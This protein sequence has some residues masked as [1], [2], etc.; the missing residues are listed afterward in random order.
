MGESRLGLVSA[1]ALVV[2]CAAWTDTVVVQGSTTFNNRLM[3]RYQ[4][5]IEASAG[6]TLTVLPSK[7]SLGL[8]A[9]FEK[10]GDI[11]MISAPLEAEV[12][13]LRKTH[14]DLPFDRLRVF[15]MSRT[16]M[17]FAVNPNNPVRSASLDEVRRV[18]LGEITNWRVL[19]GPDLP[20]R[21]VMVREGG[22]VQASIENEL[23]HG[24]H[25]NAP[26]PITV[27]ISS[28]VVKVVAQ[29]PS[30]LGLAQLPTLLRSGLPELMTDK[31]IEQRLSMVTLGEPNA[32]VKKV[33]DA[34][35]QISESASID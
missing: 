29:E 24:A 12:A 26:D 5:A 1:S 34:T 15:E 28:Q 33:I 27:Q 32:A 18:L 4:A 6:A 16:R 25:I 14:P 19:G 3:V 35:R 23:L 22:G 8:L 20:I 31:P 17:A 21:I 11:A 9:L 30:A 2:L 10:R 7:S 13:A